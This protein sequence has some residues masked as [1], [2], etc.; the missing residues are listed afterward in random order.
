MKIAVCPVLVSTCILSLIVASCSAPKTPPRVT[1]EKPKLTATSCEEANRLVYKAVQTMGYTVAEYTLARPGQAGRI[2]ATKAGAT[3]GI[4]TITCTQNSATIDARNA[5][6]LT[7][8][9]GAA[10]RPH[11][12]V[13][14]FPMSYQMVQRR[15]AYKSDNPETGT[16]QLSI[17]PLN[18]FES[19]NV[20]GTDAQASGILPVR[21]TIQNN[22]P[23]PYGI[24]AGKIFLVPEGG[25]RVAP[26]SS[27]SGGSSLQD[28]TVEPG[29]TASG[30]LYYPTGNYSSARTSVVDKE[31]DEREGF[32]VRF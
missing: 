12:F 29:Q 26:V 17:V 3:K 7:G 14:S 9:I 25:G 11:H 13:N 4:V 23:R 20:L 19:Q 10:E 16:L 24:E 31:N 6:Q 5:N 8:L 32:S 15:E 30:F 22:T 18:N 21:V 27:P 28:M 2:S 1:V